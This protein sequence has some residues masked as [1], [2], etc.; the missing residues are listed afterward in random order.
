MTRPKFAPKSPNPQNDRSVLL[1]SGKRT[2]YRCQL[3]RCWSDDDAHRA[4]SHQARS[5]AGRRPAGRLRS[6]TSPIRAF[7][8]W[9]GQVYD[10]PGWQSWIKT[11]ADNIDA[12]RFWLPAQHSADEPELIF[13]S[14]IG[15]PDGYLDWV[16]DVTHR[17][18]HLMPLVRGRVGGQFISNGFVTK[19]L[20]LSP[21]WREWRCTAYPCTKRRLIP[22]LLSASRWRVFH[23]TRFHLPTRRRTWRLAHYRAQRE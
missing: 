18:A 21:D 23:E 16:I 5:P 17:A 9:Q 19:L 4:R 8:R 13:K 12:T 10:E 1:R 11:A 15:G 22:P 7:Y 14:I 3:T 2:G 20:L 6:S